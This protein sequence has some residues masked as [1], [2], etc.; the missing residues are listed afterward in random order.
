MPT[1]KITS[2]N[3]GFATILVLIMVV[4]FV[5]IAIG[6]VAYAIYLNKAN[7][8]S[9][10][11]SQPRT[12]SQ[13]STETNQSSS[14][15]GVLQQLLDKMKTYKNYRLDITIIGGSI[16]AKNWK[17]LRFG[18][19]Q[20]HEFGEITTAYVDNKL[21]KSYTYFKEENEYGEGK[22]SD[23]EF[24]IG[25]PEYYFKNWTNDVKT[26]GDDVIDGQK[27]TVYENTNNGIT[28]TAYISADTGLPIK[29]IQKIT[30]GEVIATFKF[31]RINQV[32][33]SEVSLPAGAKKIVNL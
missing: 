26:K 10:S 19:K 22:S 8:T 6:S 7:T 28:V 16:K 29:T 13:T 5:A 23:L 2:P 9:D 18:E 17:I 30:N 12:I 25:T 24:S 21:G 1:S 4:V 20:F 14:K 27:V 3:K 33:E 11:T 15:T 31:S 32:Q